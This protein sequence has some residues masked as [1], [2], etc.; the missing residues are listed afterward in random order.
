MTVQMATTGLTRRLLLQSLLVGAGAGSLGCW[1]R[2]KPELVCPTSPG[3][4]YLEGPLT[5]DTHCHVFNGTDLQVK[6]F[7]SMV[8]VNQGGLLGGAADA[9]GSILQF[10][11]LST[12]PSGARELR[13]LAKIAGQSPSCSDRRVSDRM[14]SLRQAAYAHGR[15]EL[16]AAVEQTEHVELRNRPLGEMAGASQA[17]KARVDA[18]R[19]IDS[20]PEHVETYRAGSTLP[21][22]REMLFGGD[23]VKGFIDFLLQNFQYRYVSVHDYLRS[24]NQPGNRVVDLLLPNMVDYDFWLAK[25]DA[26][27]TP[28]STQVEVMRQISILTGGRVHSFVPFDPLREV[29]FELGQTSKG[30]FDLV[31]SAV[32]NDGCLGVKLYPPMGFAAMGNGDIK[33]PDGSNFW[34]RSWLASWTRTTPDLGKRLDAAMGKL[35]QWCEDQGVPVMAHTNQ[36]NGVSQEFQ[37]L[38]GATGWQKALSAFPDLRV[39]FG[40]FGGAS[41]P[42]SGIDRAR[43]FIKLMGTATRPPGRFAYADAGFFAEVLKERP[44]LLKTLRTLYEETKNDGEAALANR[45]MYGT[46]WEMTLTHGSIDAYLTDFIELVHDLENRAEFRAAG[47]TDLERRFF[48]RNAVNWL[49]LRSGDRARGRLETFYSRHNVPNPDWMKKVDALPPM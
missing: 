41:K 40:H 14:S 10:L 1:L 49:G 42:E 11:A 45:F 13:E 44:G 17:I 9:L 48:G 36:S 2:K 35:F 8:V 12:A 29:A 30:S 24:Y 21:D 46:D 22:D 34:D 26:T 39:N 3:V 47:L 38:A 28:L 15:A 25:G 6:K 37:D 18:V 5:I 32:E 16:Q 33:K 43:E 4:S 7:I 19:I 27:E 31:K 20:L 23:V